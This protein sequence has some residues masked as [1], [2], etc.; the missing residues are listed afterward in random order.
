ML[1]TTLNSNIDVP[2]LIVSSVG[3]TLPTHIMIYV[4]GSNN[5]GIPS[6]DATTKICDE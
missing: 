1:Q 5:L 6:N 4:S 3:F 2:I